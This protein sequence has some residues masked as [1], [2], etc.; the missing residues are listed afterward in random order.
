MLDQKAYKA[1]APKVHPNSQTA[2]QSRLV[3]RGHQTLNADIFQKLYFSTSS[4][5]A[6]PNHGSAAVQA[7]QPS[8]KAFN[9][10]AGYQKSAAPAPQRSDCTYHNNYKQQNLEGAPA[11]KEM[12]QIIASTS[13][14]G[15]STNQVLEGLPLSSDT[16]SKAF[17]GAYGDRPYPIGHVPER[18]HGPEGLIRINSDAQFLESKSC[19]QRDFKQYDEEL[20]NKSRPEMMKD[21]GV[22]A[23]KS[24][25][26]F[27]AVSS[28]KREFGKS[29]D[30]RHG[31]ARS[32]SEGVVKSA[33]QLH[34]LAFSGR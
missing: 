6:C 28:Y 14:A 7:V 32:R 12:R 22:F 8:M 34:A 20:R 18:K 19:F 30:P 5:A 25:N 17:Y 23:S 4:G 33:S 26:K 13:R 16:T 29:R 24:A 2:G 31:L 27:D 3:R 10:G 11:L 1:S 21:R 15:S 9:Q